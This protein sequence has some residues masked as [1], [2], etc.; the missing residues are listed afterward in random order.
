MT[1]AAALRTLGTWSLDSPTRRFDAEDWWYRASFPRPARSP[2]HT[3]VLGFDGLAT[4]A[5]VWLNGHH[6]LRS[7]NMFL[8]HECHV[9]EYLQDENRLLLRF[10][11]LDAHLQQKRPR[12]LWRTPMIEHQQLRYVRTTLLGRTPGW[13][14][15][16]AAVGPWRP[17]WLD[18]RSAGGAQ[19]EMSIRTELPDLRGDVGVA[20]ANCTIAARG[21]ATI[22]KVVLHLTRGGREHSAELR[23]ESAAD[24]P[25]GEIRISAARHPDETRALGARYSG[26]LHIENV[27]RWWPCTHG[28]PALYTARLSI[29]LAG[30]EEPLSIPLPSV[31]FRTLELE[32]AG[33]A[34]SL[35]ING[36]KVFCRGA[37]WTPPDPV[38]LAATP[39][40]LMEAVEQVRDAGMN[41]LRV[42]GTM[43]YESDAFL[44]AC[45]ANGIL[46][47]QDFMFA[48]MSYPNDDEAFVASV[49]REAEQMLARVAARPCLAVLC[50]NSE[51]EQQAAMW[52]APRETWQQ[53]LF[54]EVLPQL[55][56]E[57][58]PATPYWPSS[59]SGGSFPHQNNVGTTS[60]YG[61]GAYLRPLQDARLSEVKFASECLAFANIPEA[62]ALAR[63]PGGPA[64][65]MH[66]ATWK[67]RSPRDLGAGWDFDDVRDHYLATLFKVDPAQLRYADP[68]RYF[69]LSRVVTGEVM[70]ATFAEW[71]R[72][73]SVNGGG[74]IWFM[75]DLWAGAGWGIVDDAG[76]PKAAYRYLK[77]ALRPVS[78]SLSDEGTNGI[79]VHAVNESPSDLEATLD[80]ELF[81][82]SGASVGR[83][84]R[85]LQ[86]PARRAGEW[87]ATDW[88][89]GFLDLSYAYRFGPP[90]HDLIVATL[91]N[92][93]DVELDRAHHFD[94]AATAANRNDLG[95]SASAAPVADGRYDVEI[96]TRLFAQSVSIE[97]EGYAVDDDY[98]HVAPG[99]IRKVQLR[100]L[101]GERTRPLRARLH[102]LNQFS[103]V[104]VEVPR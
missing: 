40:A 32:T 43:V 102:A 93:A 72:Q 52:G 18:I 34:F 13:S 26:E 91:R 48:N 73:R 89:P 85:T 64:V 83:G 10:K 33:G 44:D 100:S 23:R 98:F 8:A 36:V 54:S 62:S 39:E 9:D 22:E 35:R 63:M 55:V 20:R 78:V 49:R 50:G 65:R 19:C 17:V 12:P 38:S 41:M 79:F 46:L 69:A 51:G 104:K 92:G 5:D 66:H 31:G 24:D 59:A 101:A 57:R 74:L 29:Q 58:C 2:T 7:D 90:G 60:Y 28:E 76:A 77:R 96:R 71:R 88:F 53:K 21:P 99:A 67:A 4:L 27:A 45:D 6:L 68:D 16:A 3:S 25:R 81:R 94:L 14:P 86:L 37:C 11:S 82:S 15:P 61:V 75:R 1:V 103:P 70:G 47:W 80:I 30:S 95:L 84:S 97:A 56:R 87:P 42:G